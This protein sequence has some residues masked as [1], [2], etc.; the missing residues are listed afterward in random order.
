MSTRLAQPQALKHLLRNC[1]LLYGMGFCLCLSCATAATAKSYGYVHL[2][3]YSIRTARGIEPEKRF[4]AAP[5][6]LETFVE[7]LNEDGTVSVTDINKTEWR[8][9]SKICDEKSGMYCLQQIGFAVPRHVEL[10]VGMKWY[11]G[12]KA[13]NS[14]GSF[15]PASYR[16]E[17]KLELKLAGRDFDVFAIS[18][19][20]PCNYQLNQCWKRMYYYSRKDGLVAYTSVLLSSG[21]VVDSATATDLPGFGAEDLK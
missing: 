17:D 8:S 7:K 6:Q 12:D 9:V 21:R 1:F 3:G 4:V 19:A 20:R 18:E 14:G 5:L 13:V 15:E 16:I 2:T 10:S 11:H